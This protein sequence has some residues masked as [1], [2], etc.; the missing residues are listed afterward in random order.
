MGMPD[1]LR[2]EIV[3]A[4]I[5]LKEGGMATTDEIKR[6][7]LERMADYKLPRQIVFVKELPKRTGNINRKGFR[8][9][10]SRLA[11]FLRFPHHDR[12]KS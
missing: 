11:G 10:L 5:R 4:F 3:K 6:F 8:P 12:V 1:K 7:C 2:G 9:W